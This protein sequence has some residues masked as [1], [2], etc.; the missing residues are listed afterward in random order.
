[1]TD[2]A[3]SP[4]Q[5][6]LK[7]DN[8]ETP[9]A[10]QEHVAQIWDRAR[11]NAF[12]HRV[13]AESYRFWAT[14]YFV[15]QVVFGIFGVLL[16]LGVYIVSASEKL[17]YFGEGLDEIILT[18][19]SVVFSISSLFFSIIQNYMGFEK[20]EQ[21]HDHNQHSFLFIA[22]RAREVRFPEIGKA[23][24]LEILQDL[25]RDFQALKAR[26][27]EPS[28]KHFTKGD[29]ILDEVKSGSSSRRQSFLRKAAGD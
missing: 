22:Q 4:D 21:L 9:T 20:L 23:R 14:L 3:N 8:G 13:A 24:S 27:K 16:V 18:F 25:E 6:N 5:E 2:D 7:R 12:A 11:S 1:M 19:A 28:D 26:G 17:H 15:L 29:K 10:V